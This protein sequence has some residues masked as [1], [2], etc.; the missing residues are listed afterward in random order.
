MFYFYT[1]KSLK[2]RKNYYGVTDNIERRLKEH[3]DGKNKSTR[4]RMP[5]VLIYTKEF[6][7]KSAAYKY[8]WQV[9]HDGDTNKRLKK[10]L[11]EMA[12]VVKA[13]V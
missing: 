12:E 5:F 3:N 9:K 6:I 13:H 4:Y 7:D 1:L 2:D 8:E 10:V 11:A